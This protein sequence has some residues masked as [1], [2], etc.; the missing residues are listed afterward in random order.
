[1]KTII[2]LLKTLLLSHFPSGS[3]INYHDGLLYLIG[4]DANELLV[5]DSN[6]NQVNAVKLFNYD[7][8]RIPKAQKP[9][10]E[11]S[12]ILNGTLLALGSGATKE[13]EIAVTV[14]LPLNNSQPFKSSY[15]TFIKRLHQITEINIEGAA[16][17]GNHVVLSNRGNEANPVNHFIITSTDFISQQETAPIRIISLKLPLPGFAGVSELC[18]AEKEDILFVILSSEATS[19]AYDDGAIGDSYFAWV[20]NIS[21]KLNDKEIS[22]DGIVN[23]SDVDAAFKGEKVEGVCISSITDNS[24]IL[25]L[26]AD[27]DK[28]ASRLFQVNVGVKALLD[29]SR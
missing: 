5:L 15:S 11:T 12:V 26:V 1:M 22:L 29:S 8:K 10:L 21:R 23:L 25:H 28:G 6:Y 3:S 2:T 9:D 14:S 7:G 18:Y 17:I 27:D 16:V 19:N 4:D 13:R 24:W 20:N